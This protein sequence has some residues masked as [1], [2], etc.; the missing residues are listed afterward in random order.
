M[1]IALNPM[2]SE[3]KILKDFGEALKKRREEK[4]LSQEKLAELASLHR[5]YI[6]AVER[7]EKNISLINLDKLSHAFKIELKELL[8]F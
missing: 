3:N 6:G 4:K 7:G 8:T 2:S 5:T 1:G